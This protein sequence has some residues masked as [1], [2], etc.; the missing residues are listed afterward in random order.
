M[1]QVLDLTIGQIGMFVR[2]INKRQR[3][4]VEFQATLHN[5]KLKGHNVNE[6]PK[7]S[8]EQEAAAL[9]ANDEAL[10]RVKERFN[11][12]KRSNSKNRR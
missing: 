2:T 8:Q 9:K 1:D 5:M 4:D 3:Q 6:A 10:M 7:L 11:R 12:G